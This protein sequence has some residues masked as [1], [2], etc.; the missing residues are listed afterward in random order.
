MLIFGMG[1]VG[2]RL[3]AALVAE[4]W[5][6]AGVG[7]ATDGQL[8][9][10]NDRSA[11]EAAIADATH[12]IST[13]AP[14]DEGDPVLKAYADQLIGSGAGW[15]GYISSTGVYGDTGG[16]WVD[17]SAAIG[18]GRRTARS[19]ADSA[20]QVLRADVRVLRLP[21]I[22][23]PGRS[24][25]DRIAAGRAHRIDLPAQIFSRIHVDDIVSAI[26]ASFNGPAGVYNISDDRPAPQNAVIEYASALLGVTPPPLQSLDEAG[27]SPL[28]RAFYDENRRISNR[29]AKRLIGWSPQ[30]S[31]Y[32]QGLDEILKQE[33]QKGN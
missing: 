7:R 19:D 18:A 30:Y 11:V 2:S 20:W 12:I 33:V 24:P 9:C 32:K 23:G 14:D 26:M 1:Y 10:I 21:G 5:S 6:I 31:D 29:K 8:L 15:I 16:A 3:A 27:L 13:I 25:F 4:G 22:Y 28:A 17:E